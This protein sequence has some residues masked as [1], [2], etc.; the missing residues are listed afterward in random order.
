MLTKSDSK[1][2]A[3]IYEWIESNL[4]DSSAVIDGDTPLLEGGILDSFALISLMSIVQENSENVN[5]EKL[6]DPDNFKT[7]NKIIQQFS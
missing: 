1:L 7:I 6:Y 4:K 3:L 5:E 2:I